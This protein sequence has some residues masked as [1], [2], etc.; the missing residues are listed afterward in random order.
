MPRT[1]HSLAT[2][3][4]REHGLALDNGRWDRLAAVIEAAEDKDAILKAF[5]ADKQLILDAIESK[6]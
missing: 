4:S 2:E 1:S 6:E 3:L 5:R